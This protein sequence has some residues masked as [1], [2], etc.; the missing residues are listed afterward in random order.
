M[1]TIKRWS[2]EETEALATMRGMLGDVLASVDQN[3]EVVGDR[4]LLRFYRGHLG[5][6]DTACTY[7]RNY[8]NWR[9][10][11]GIDQ[12]RREI[13]HGGLNTPKK[14]PHGDIFTTM[15]PQTISDVNGCSK[16]GLPVTIMRTNFSPSA[17]L[18]EKSIEQYIEFVKYTLEY[19]TL[20]LEQLA[21]KKEREILQQ[22]EASGEPLTEP[23]GVMLQNVVIRDLGGITLEHIGAKGQSITKAVI[24][25]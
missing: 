9:K 1:S 16:D 2:D 13:V 18:E 10:E 21:E 5:V 6:M 7:L 20:I 25:K 4:C 11:N 24:G 15:L 8:L 19:Q 22:A 12:I 23:Y 3:V 17:I 14:F